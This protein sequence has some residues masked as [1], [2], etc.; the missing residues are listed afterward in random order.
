MQRATCR[1]TSSI[2]C[3]TPG[4]R[5]R[6]IEVLSAECVLRHGRRRALWAQA[7]LGEAFGR[8]APACRT[9]AR[10]SLGFSHREQ[11][12]MAEFL[13]TAQMPDARHKPGLYP[14]RPSPVEFE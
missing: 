12:R 13:L 1:T 8:G 14:L 2:Y 11:R 6:R 4:G 5:R 3:T 7:P 9:L 10:P